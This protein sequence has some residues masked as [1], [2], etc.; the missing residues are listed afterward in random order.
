MRYV[1]ALAI[2]PTPTVGVLRDLP[3]GSETRQTLRYMRD[4]VHAALTDPAQE[5]RLQALSITASCRERD[6][7]GEVATLQEWVRDNIKFVRDPE[8]F[9]LVQTPQKTLEIGAGDCDDKST[10]LAAL[11]CAL[12]HPAQFV[13]IGFEGAPHSHVLVRTKVG[14]TWL[15]CETILRGVTVGWWPQGVTSSYILKV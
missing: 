2:E 13:A 10:L 15:P 11:L 7:Y 4:M 6:W 1:G 12:G 8:Q 5:I 9:E 14:D 3:M